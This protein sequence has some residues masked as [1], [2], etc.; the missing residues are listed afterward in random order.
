MTCDF[1]PSGLSANN[2]NNNNNKHLLVRLFALGNPNAAIR[3]ELL[4][5]LV[6]VV[7][8]PERASVHLLWRIAGLDLLRTRELILSKSGSRTEALTHGVRFVVRARSTVCPYFLF[9]HFT[10]VYSYICTLFVLSICAVK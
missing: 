6:S 8:R 2:N 5:D 4:R 3:P 7:R 10:V 1:W 9:V